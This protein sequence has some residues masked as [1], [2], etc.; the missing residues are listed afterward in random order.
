MSSLSDCDYLIIGALTR[1]VRVSK[2]LG[3]KSFG[4]TDESICGECEVVHGVVL[5]ARITVLWNHGTG[6]FALREM[7]DVYRIWISTG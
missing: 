4:A 5:A 6:I 7:N 1:E 3:N 2:G